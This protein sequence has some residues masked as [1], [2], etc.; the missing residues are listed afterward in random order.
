M[1]PSSSSSLSPP[2]QAPLLTATDLRVD[3]DGVPL[4]E[5]VTFHCSG[6]SAVLLGEGASLVRTAQREA[7]IVAGRLSAAGCEMGRDDPRLV[8]RRLGIAPLDPALPGPM[9]V[10]AY[11]VA[12]ARLA[13][14]ARRHAERAASQTLAALGL[15]ELAPRPL[16]HLHRPEARAVVLAQAVV[17][18][19]VALLAHA[20]AQGLSGGEADFVV[21]AF[22]AACEGRRWIVCLPNLVPRSA[23][24]TWLASADDIVVFSSGRLVRQTSS[25]ELAHGAT[26]Y[27]LIV[28]GDLAAFRH[29][30][31]VR[32]VTLSGGPARFWI[33]LPA[34][35]TPTDLLALSIAA[36]APIVELYPRLLGPA[37][38]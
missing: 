15:D 21:R 20:P 14:L 24:A 4:F 23:D 27:T 1:M 30:L 25:A 3:A 18:D 29:A 37:Q 12:G 31:S 6:Q 35:M 7:R 9:T 11:L 2:T 28:H 38:W 34:H 19:P 33:D 13:G 32:G 17:T 22:R 36:Q 16:A 8:A 10:Q 26:G 5:Y